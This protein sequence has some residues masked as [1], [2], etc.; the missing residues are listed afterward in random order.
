MSH[1]RARRST[2]GTRTRTRTRGRG[3]VIAG[4]AV[5]VCVGLGFAGWNLAGFGAGA[6]GI[7]VTCPTADPVDVG[8]ITVPAGPVAG[9]CQDRLVNAAHIMNA[10][11]DLGIGTH[12]QTVG[13]MTAL[14]ESGLRVLD[15]GDAA[16][17]D[18]RG[19][20]QQRDNGAW[21][22]L[23]DRMDPYVSAQ[24]FFTKLTKVA[25]WKEMEPTL[26][27]HAVQV[28]ADPE[29]YAAYWARAE[30]IVAALAIPTA[31]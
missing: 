27:A 20:F 23:A 25:G 5:A 22:T 17:A 2:T 11:R 1:S 19:L 18:S 9:Y 3:L 13:V 6:A 21:G 14:G 10:G 30:D 4:V 26:L 15:Y 12:T 16:G 24:N 29:H 7:T 31:P 8:A 28:N